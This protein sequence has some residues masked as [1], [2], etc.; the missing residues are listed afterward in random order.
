MGLVVV[1]RYHELVFPSVSIDFQMTLDET[2]EAASVFLFQ[3]AYKVDTYRAVTAFYY[4]D[5]T[6]VYLERELGP[7]RANAVMQRELSIWRLCTRFFRPSEQEEFKVSFSPT[8]RL[9]GFTCEVGEIRKAQ[10]CRKRRQYD[11]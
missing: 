8:G 10:F 3:Q 9:V 4:D 5:D 7:E 11:P 6:K 2:E 1:V